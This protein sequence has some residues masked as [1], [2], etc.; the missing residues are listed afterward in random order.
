MSDQLV[1]AGRYLHDTK[2]KQETDMHAISVNL[3]MNYILGCVDTGIA[4][5]SITG[6]YILMRFLV[7]SE[8]FSWLSFRES[9]IVAL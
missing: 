5:F 1:A 2:P 4:Q 8:V 3:S 7:W 6:S 9:F